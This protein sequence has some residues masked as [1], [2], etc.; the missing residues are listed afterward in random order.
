M[1]TRNLCWTGPLYLNS[2]LSP[3]QRQ[4]IAGNIYLFLVIFRDV[5]IV[6]ATSAV[7]LLL[8]TN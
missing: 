4:K 5:K 3:I 7:G 6:G 8:V 1:T 2:D